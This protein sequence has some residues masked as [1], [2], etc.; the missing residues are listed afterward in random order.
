MPNLARII[1]VVNVVSVSVNPEETMMNL[2][3]ELI[4]RYFD[5]WLSQ[6]HVGFSQWDNY[7]VESTIR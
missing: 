4:K 6:P 7:Q 3:K 1:H 5:Y 2:M